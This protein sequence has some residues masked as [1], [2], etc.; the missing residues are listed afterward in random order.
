MP[1]NDLHIADPVLTARVVLT[2]Y[3][4]NVILAVLSVIPR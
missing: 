2:L 4:A 3:T 1:L